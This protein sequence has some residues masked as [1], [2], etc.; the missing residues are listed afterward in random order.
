MLVFW[1]VIPC[2]PVGRHQRFGRPYFLHL[3]HWSWRPY[4]PEKRYLPTSPHGITT[5]KTNINL[6]WFVYIC[7]MHRF[8]LSIFIV[9]KTKIKNK[10]I[11]NQTRQRSIRKVIKI[12]NWYHYIKY[13][14]E[15]FEVTD[16]DIWNELYN[17]SILEKANVLNLW[18]E[19]IDKI[20]VEENWK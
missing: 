13:E 11:F 2:G 7:F 17:L 3:H 8:N 1:V 16:K 12:K 20:R 14:M 19:Y 5:Q 4:V 15:E 9:H 18:W 10:R 6:Y